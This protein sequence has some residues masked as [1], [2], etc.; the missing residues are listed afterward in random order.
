MARTLGDPFSLAVTLNTLAS[1][2]L[3]L[4]K[5]E[6]ARAHYLEALEVGHSMGGAGN[7]AIA[8][9]GFAELATEVE[10]ERAVELLAASD[11][12]SRERAQLLDGHELER[13]ERTLADLRGRL[14]EGRVRGSPGLRRLAVRS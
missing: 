12:I 3:I 8:L 5:V 14:S 2:E 11:S 4:G 6:H 10:P 1:A 7:V 9:L 13:W